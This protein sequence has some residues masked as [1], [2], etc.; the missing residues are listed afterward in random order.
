MLDEKKEKQV[1]V[2]PHKK[3]KN[4]IQ[5]MLKRKQRRNN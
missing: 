3:V 1:M 4:L 2:L 5:I